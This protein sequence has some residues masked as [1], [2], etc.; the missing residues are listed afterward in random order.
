MEIVS[1][2]RVNIEQNNGP[3]CFNHLLGS[4]N[5][6]ITGFAILMCHG[7]GGVLL[8][9]LKRHGVF[10]VFVVLQGLVPGAVVILVFLD[11]SALG[12]SL[13]GVLVFRDTF[14]AGVVNRTV[15]RRRMCAAVGFRSG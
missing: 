6:D 1:N 5:A 15:R 14:S 2:F 9:R 4:R 12:R 3:F 8:P 13:V 10:I 11:A 7:D